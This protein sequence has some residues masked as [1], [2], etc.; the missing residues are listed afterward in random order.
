MYNELERILDK[1]ESLQKRFSIYR[2]RLLSNIFGD[3]IDNR[4]IGEIHAKIRKITAISGLPQ[5]YTKG[6]VDYAIKLSTKAKRQTKNMTPLDVAIGVYALFTK[7]QSYQ[8]ITK[9]TNEILVKY[10]AEQKEITI[11]KEIEY[12]RKLENPRIFYLSSEHNDCALDHRDWQGKVYIDEKW[13]S[14]VKDED[15]KRQVRDYLRTHK[16]LT[17]QWVTS[18]PVWFIT[19]PHCRH[20]FRALT[21]DDIIHKPLKKLITNYKMHQKIGKRI[22]Q[23]LAHPTNKKWYKVTNIENIIS[24]YESRLQ[25]HE[26]LYS[27]R[28]LLD[29]KKAIE[30]DKFLIKKWKKYLT[31]IKSSGTLK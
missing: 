1:E 6:I 20:Y 17:F 8:R 29:L 18:K 12:N 11:Q 4:P 15:R 27:K 14:Y 21:I 13:E 9:A 23:T 31:E 2:N 3:V 16:V 10:E 7:E 28:K 5:Q 25:Y 26:A 30:K 22:T 19:R 24:R